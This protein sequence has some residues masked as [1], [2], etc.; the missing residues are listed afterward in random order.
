LFLLSKLQPVQEHASFRNFDFTLTSLDRPFTFIAIST[1]QAQ[2][3]SY[4]V[5]AVCATPV[6]GHLRP[7]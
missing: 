3:L 2:M 1:L 7:R 4:V 6:T 5:L